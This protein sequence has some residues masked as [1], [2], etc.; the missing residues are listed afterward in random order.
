LTR[1]PPAP[2]PFPSTTLFRSAASTTTAPTA[3]S[4]EV[5]GPVAMATSSET[6]SATAAAAAQPARLPA[7]PLSVLTGPSLD[8]AGWPR[9][10]RQIG[11]H[12][13]ELQS[14]E[15]LVCRL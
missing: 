12:T 4:G 3:T 1:L 9:Q 6:P 13:S 10:P 8:R 7:T 5:R 2:P 11:R 14:R 15:N